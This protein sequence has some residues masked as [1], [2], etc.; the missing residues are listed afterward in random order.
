[1]EKKVVVRIKRLLC[2]LMI[3]VL[4]GTTNTY[5]ASTGIYAEENE[6][7]VEDEWDEVDVGDENVDP[8]PDLDVDSE[9]V[10][11]PDPV[12]GV[13]YNLTTYTKNVSFGSLTKNQLVE[14]YP[15]VIKNESTRDVSLFW[16]E[17][18]IEQAFTVN[19]PSNLYMRVGESRTFYILPN[20]TVASGSHSATI[21]F[22]DTSDPDLIYGLTVNL[23]FNLESLTPHIDGISVSPA[24]VSAATGSVQ[25]FTAVVRGENNPNTSVTWEVNGNS[26][27]DTYVDGDGILHVSTSER[28]RNIR[29]TATSVQDP[30]FSATA[31]VN[32]IDTDYS[33]SVVADPY[34]GGNVN[35]GG[36]VAA[37]GS[38]TVLAAPNIT[39]R[40]AGWYLDGK[41][42]SNQAKYTHSNINSNITLVAKFTKDTHYVT[43]KS[44]HGEAG[45]IT[46]S[47]FVNDGDSLKIQ[48]V[49]KQGWT[50]EGWQENGN[51]LSKDSTYNLTNIKS[52]RVIT[53]IF[54]PTQFTIS[55]GVNPKDCGKVSG[56]GR[57]QKG[58]N[59]KIKAEPYDGYVFT[60]WTYNG[61]LVSKDA[62]FVI[63]NVTQDYYVVANFEKKGVKTYTISAGVCSNDGVISPAGDSKV[64]EGGSMLY[65]IAPKSGYRVLAVAVDNVQV[66]AVTSYT[67][68]NVKANHTI[69]VAFAP[70]EK[71]KP[72]SDG[73]GKKDNTEKPKPGSVS[74]TDTI[75]PKDAVDPDAQPIVDDISDDAIDEGEGYDYDGQ[76][77][78]VQDLNLTVDEATDID[79]DKFADVMRQAIHTG[80]LQVAIFN[81]Y[82]RGQTIGAEGDFINSAALPNLEKVVDSLLS[83]DD[84]QDIVLGTPVKINVNIFEN[85]K[86]ISEEDKKAIDSTVSKGVTIGNYF[87]IIL[88]K[89]KNGECHSVT[90]LPVGMT[91]CLDVP[92]DLQDAGRSFYIVREHITSDGSVQLAILPD[93]DNNPN[94]VTF[95]TDKFSSYAIAYQGGNSGKTKQISIIIL[96]AAIAVMVLMI[97]LLTGRSVA[98]SKRRRVR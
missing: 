2:F 63:K 77:G 19:A 41:L 14:Y 24:N 88:M 80:T 6:E 74:E 55:L 92:K 64:Q 89:S 8:S 16:N 34:D 35:G 78:V 43:L 20:T 84:I 62:E 56:A 15:L 60:G 40:F 97:A 32:I 66:G 46:A 27:S 49:S 23:S 10:D 13:G 37:G 72:S 11:D 52:D 82:D 69:A 83:K 9:D 29:V 39:Y 53:A 85:S 45:S 68:T 21:R 70:L 28:S 12:V 33:V 58:F 30:S 95:T 87:E 31:Y 1:M 38:M 65:T 98:A 54:S 3:F 44:N 91:I 79:S 48:A 50:F 17:S 5:F 26:A 81:E 22:G 42:L 4:I 47:Q 57:I 59:S 18:D 75:T 51:L 94:T 7:I 61:N 36:S 90:E 67:F 96:V 86:F 76:E 73:S 93:E 71:A 25:R